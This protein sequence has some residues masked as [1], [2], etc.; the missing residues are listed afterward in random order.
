MNVII[1]TESRSVCW[2]F[3]GN[4]PTI[5]QG[6]RI[7]AY[8]WSSPT[9]LHCLAKAQL[10]IF[11]DMTANNKPLGHISFSYLQTKFK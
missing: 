7:A 3:T 5:H 4:M 1:K 9:S 10:I 11:F 8:R 2:K 6:N